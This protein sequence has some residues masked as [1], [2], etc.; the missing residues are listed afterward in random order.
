MMTLQL[1]ILKRKIKEVQ[2]QSA[3]DIEAVTNMARLQHDYRLSQLENIS[4]LCDHLKTQ[5]NG[6]G[7]LETKPGHTTGSSM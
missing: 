4:K 3:A 1:N 7:K 5:E 6:N 2:A